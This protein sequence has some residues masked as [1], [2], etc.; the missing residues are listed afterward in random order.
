MSARSCRGS[1]VGAFVV[2]AASPSLRAAP[3]WAKMVLFKHLEADPHELYPIADANGPWMIM[4]A[5]FSGEGAE[6][7]ARS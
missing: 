4:A 7:Q 1:F 6:E 5:T 2:L 3:P